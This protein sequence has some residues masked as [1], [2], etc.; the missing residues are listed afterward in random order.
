QLEPKTQ[1]LLI[2]A[3][4]EACQWGNDWLEQKEQDIKL[5]FIKSSVAITE[6]SPEELNKFKEQSRP[7]IDQLKMQYDD[8]ACRA[9]GIN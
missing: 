5:D 4:K 7:M 3:S 8:E 9:F 6:L 1:E 2:R